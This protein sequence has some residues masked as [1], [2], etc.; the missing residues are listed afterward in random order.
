MPSVARGL[1][2]LTSSPGPGPPRPVPGHHFTPHTQPLVSPTTPLL[3]RWPQHGENWV[4]LSP[5]SPCSLGQYSVSTPGG[6]RG[7][8]PGQGER[9]CGADRPTGRPG[10]GP[11]LAHTHNIGQTRGR[12]IH[13]ISPFQVQESGAVAVLIKEATPATCGLG[14]T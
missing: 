4:C 1:T 12:T 6:G 7:A 3:P 13:I 10:P 8:G 14:L 5:P 2:C 11:D 9:A